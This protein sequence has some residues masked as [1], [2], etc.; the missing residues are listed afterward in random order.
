MI[1]TS[2]KW[3]IKRAC[4]LLRKA[5]AV[6]CFLAEEVA[7]VCKLRGPGQNEIR[8][9]CPNRMALSRALSLYKK[10]PE[11]IRWIDGFLPGDT[12]LDIGANVGVFSLYA[13]M[14]GHRVVAVEPESQNYSLLNTNL[15]INDLGKTVRAYNMALSDANRAS[16]LFL[17]GF[18]AARALHTVGREVDYK[19]QVMKASFCQGA[20]EMTLDLFVQSL[21]D[22]YPTHLKID[23]DGA[24][25][26]II[27]GAPNTLRDSRLKS[28]LVELNE[29]LPCDLAIIKQLRTLGFKDAVREHSAIFNTGV[30]S[31]TYNYVFVR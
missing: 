27:C 17:S 16:T 11:T 15:F 24:E 13:A 12:F 5:N 22:F 18:G 4:S 6:T 25:A 26:R 21:T 10:E 19:H 29:E 2:A 3:L 31:G 9:Y 20:W 8:F 7:P 23:V 28:I 1:R 14:R 30:F